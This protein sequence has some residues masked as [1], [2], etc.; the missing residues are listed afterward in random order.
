MFMQN[1]IIIPEIKEICDKKND[2]YPLFDAFIKIDKT[3]VTTDEVL[4]S[5]DWGGSERP[6]YVAK[7][8]AV[9]FFRELRQAG[10]GKFVVGRKTK[11]SRFIWNPLA[12][13]PAP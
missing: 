12:R 10:L 5:V 11:K 4:R 6:E 1:S 8:L 13:D 7:K 9:D 2:F 3:V